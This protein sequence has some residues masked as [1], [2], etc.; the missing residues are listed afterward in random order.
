VISRNPADGAEVTHF[1]ITGITGGLLFKNNGTTPINNGDFITFAEGNT[2]LKFT[3]HSKRQLPG[4]GISQR[5]GCGLSSL[6]GGT[7][8]ATIIINPLGG[9]IRFSA[10]NYTVAEG[11]GFKTITIERSGDTSQAVTVDYASTDHS[12]T[13]DFISCS[14]PGAGFASSRCDLLR[15]SARCG[16]RRAKRR[17]PSTF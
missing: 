11:A 7:A 6:S 2:G 4:A 13:A 3:R 15:R 8:T 16:L 17:K 12:A 14:S 10:A 5:L 9:V 1:K